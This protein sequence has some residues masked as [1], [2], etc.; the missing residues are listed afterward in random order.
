M[1]S[2]FPVFREELYNVQMDVKQLHQVQSSH[3]ERLAR[4]EKHQANES[5][6]KSAWNSPF[7]S[8]IGGTPQHG[9]FSYPPPRR[10]VLTRVI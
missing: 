2:R 10:P 8:A 3:A 6:I 4:L 7:P 9:E 1:D 5:A